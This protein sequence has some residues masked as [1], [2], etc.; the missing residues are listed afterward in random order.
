M[1]SNE[2][3]I[4]MAQ[5]LVEGGRPTANLERAEEFICD[6]ADRGC[7]LVV[8]PECLDLGW[9]DPSARQ[10]AQPI[11]GT[12]SQRLALAASEAGLYVVA[13]LVERAANQLYNSAVLIDPL[14]GILLVHR[15]INELK[16]AL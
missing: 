6:A 3:K 2:L 10:M 11:P 7:H 12:F 15:K 13:G 4:G 14:G 1:A 5:M 9:T 8:L 16:I